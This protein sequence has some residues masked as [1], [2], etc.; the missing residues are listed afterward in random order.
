VTGCL[1]EEEGERE[2]NGMGWIRRG[3]GSKRSRS[4]LAGWLVGM[5]GGRAVLSLLGGINADGGAGNAAGVH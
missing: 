4:R 3:G 5:L 1:V 2:M